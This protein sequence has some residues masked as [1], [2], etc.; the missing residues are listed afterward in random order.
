MENIRVTHKLWLVLIAGVCGVSFSAWFPSGPLEWF[1]A[2]AGA[3]SQNGN[4]IPAF[5]SAS[6]RG[7]AFGGAAFIADPGPAGA[8]LG[9]MQRSPFV[10]FQD[11]ITGLYPGEVTYT[12]ELD[13][14]DVVNLQGAVALTF[15]DVVVEGDAL[16]RI[17][18]TLADY[19]AP[20][21]FFLEG[22]RLVQGGPE[23]PHLLPQTERLLTRIV[24]EGHSLGNHSFH[25]P[26]FQA[27]E[28][29]ESPG[30][31]ERIREE[32]EHLENVV[33]EAL[34]VRL[35][36]ATP[37]RYVRPPFGARAV[38]APQTPE[39][40]AERRAT[41]T[42][43]AQAA[44]EA[45]TA[46]KGQAAE[47]G[48]TASNT[49]VASDGSQYA[50]DPDAQA[51]AEAELAVAHAGLVD[52]VL[53]ERGSVLVNWHVNSLDWQLGLPPDHH[54]HATPET[55]IQATVHGSPADVYGTPS[56]GLRDTGGGV[57]LFHANRRTAEVLPDVL[58]KIAGSRTQDGRAFRFVRVRDVLM[59][60]YGM[61]PPVPAHDE[62]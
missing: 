58:E 38:H 60:K 4:R 56:D 2:G 47:E 29:R 41:T 9:V 35:A 59:M 10:Y 44:R 33:A 46:S 23:D 20:A 34:P 57:V 40:F 30:G 16:D 6:N 51:M 24:E 18:D 32:L 48:R 54:Y 13:D 8:P 19:G 61:V 28:Y 15:D 3:Y 26:N 50:S 22:R 21:T 36:G 5:S 14:P 31:R 39:A 62:R 53:A 11:P 1:G 17:L 37:I 25:H 43:E 27:A 42:S 12:L 55:V 45:Q 7:G 49:Q 52:E